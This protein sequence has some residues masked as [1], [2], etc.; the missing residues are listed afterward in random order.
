VSSG[1][2]EKVTGKSQKKKF[3]GYTGEGRNNMSVWLCV[4]D[5]ELKVKENSK[6][7]K[8]GPPFGPTKKDKRNRRISLF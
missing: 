3:R 1:I 6:D 8:L 2:P 5:E 7:G 4:R